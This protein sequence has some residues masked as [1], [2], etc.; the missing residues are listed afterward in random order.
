[1]RLKYGLMTIHSDFFFSELTPVDLLGWCV[2][3]RSETAVIMHITFSC[4]DHVP[5]ALACRNLYG[6]S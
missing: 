1:M 4:V 2:R 3:S 6:R 5:I